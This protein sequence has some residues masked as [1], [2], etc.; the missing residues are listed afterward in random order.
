[1][2]KSNSCTFE[3]FPKIQPHMSIQIFRIIIAKGAFQP[4]LLNPFGVPEIHHDIT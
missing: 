3:L 2:Q 4:V 1:M